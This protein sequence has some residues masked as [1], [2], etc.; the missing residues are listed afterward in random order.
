MKLYVTVKSLGKRKPALAR[1]EL[2]LPEPPKSLEALLTSIVSVQ[3]QEFK[4]RQGQGEV[5][6]FLTGNEIQAQGEIGKVGF[7][8]LYNDAV[9]DE[10]KAIAAALL[11]FKDGLYR[12]F[13][14]DEEYTGLDDPLQLEEGAELVL[15]RFTMLAG[16]LW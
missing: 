11:A 9:P 8:S 16:S 5:I 2:V 12:V 3:V 1:R 13:L 10:E 4:D 6:P 15:I 14:Q 7:G